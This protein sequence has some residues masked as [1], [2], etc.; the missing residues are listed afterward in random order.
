MD[1]KLYEELDQLLDGRPEPE[2]APADNH[3]L[4]EVADTLK[5]MGTAIPESTGRAD[6]RRQLLEEMRD[7]VSRGTLGGII[8]WFSG[9][10]RRKTVALLLASTMTFSGVAVAAAGSLPGS[11]LYPLKRVVEQARALAA[12]G[13]R[14]RAAAQLDLAENRLAE[15]RRLVASGEYQALPAL[16]KAFE[17]HIKVALESANELPDATGKPLIKRAR[18][19]VIRQ[20]ELLNTLLRSKDKAR[21]R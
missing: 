2:G 18:R 6:I 19:L 16:A 7:P 17:S 11:P 1:K 4:A 5:I 14:N 13:H 20:F 3:A 15:M 10:F 9:S 8:G 12:I 21:S